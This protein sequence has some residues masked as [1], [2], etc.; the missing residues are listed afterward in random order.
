MTKKRPRVET[1]NL[2]KAQTLS[3]NT[4][5]PMANSIWIW[6]WNPLI[7]NLKSQ[8]KNSA[9]VQTRVFMLLIKPYPCIFQEKYCNPKQTS[10]QA[11]DR[12]VLSTN[13][14]FAVVAS[15]IDAFS[16]NWDDFVLLPRTGRRARSLNKK[17]ISSQ[18]N[19]NIVHPQ[20]LICFSSGFKFSYP[21]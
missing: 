17:T 18:I 9:R 3:S 19:Q 1:E 8:G 12:K 6:I 13:H 7:L 10:T 4:N 16:G 14:Y 2:K 15:L 20:C 5:K 11:A 21:Q